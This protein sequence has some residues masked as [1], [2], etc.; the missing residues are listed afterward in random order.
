MNVGN[1]TVLYPTPA[2]TRRCTIVSAARKR[3]RPAA[4]SPP[5][6]PG[7]SIPRP[8]A[9][10]VKCDQPIEIAHPFA[11]PTGPLRGRATFP[12]WREGER[13]APSRHFRSTAHGTGSAPMPVGPDV[14]LV[15]LR[16]ASRSALASSPR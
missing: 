11:H 10:E 12:G 5:F 15:N 16:S 8:G 1:T 14:D 2:T 6:A 3:R 4:A 9:R 7:G 13:F